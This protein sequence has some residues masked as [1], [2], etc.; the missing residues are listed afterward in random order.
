M[1]LQ[2]P[3]TDAMRQQR[4]NG[5]FPLTSTTEGECALD[6]VLGNGLTECAG[7]THAAPYSFAAAGAGPWA[8]H[9]HPLSQYPQQHR[10]PVAEPQY[11]SASNT[12]TTTQYSPDSANPYTAATPT[13]F[14]SPNLAYTQGGN[15]AF[16]PARSMS[17]GELENLPQ[18]F[19]YQN[20]PYAQ[21]ESHPAYTL[22]SQPHYGHN[23]FTQHGPNSMAQHG[24]AAESVPRSWSSAPSG[25]L[26][27]AGSH[28]YQQNLPPTFYAQQQPADVYDPRNQAQSTQNHFYY[29]SAHPG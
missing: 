21:Q 12:P 1:N 17:Y 28:A 25:Q 27:V 13:N 18:Q 10:G 5:G 24:V 6:G 3:K 15:P 22:P 7:F 19:S 8:E 14:S 4:D 26:S 11:W 29:P 16:I 2:S 20:A 23:N 9:Q